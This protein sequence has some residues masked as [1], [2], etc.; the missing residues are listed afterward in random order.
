MEKHACNQETKIND[1]FK[2]QGETQSL[3]IDLSGSLSSFRKEQI[4]NEKEALEYRKEREE[5]DK[6][7]EDK[8]DALS[9]QISSLIE[10]NTDVKNIKIAWNLGTIFGEKL[11]KIT[12]GAT[13]IL[14][15]LYA[16]KKWI[17]GAA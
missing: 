1:L 9:T 13:V 14:G 11:V 5:R 3:I 6:V 16:I 12:L 7:M 10:L 17:S 8:I 4:E 15:A 2:H